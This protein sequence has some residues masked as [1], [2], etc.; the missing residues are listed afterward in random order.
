VDKLPLNKADIIDALAA[1]VDISK[2]AATKALNVVLDTICSAL[3]SG[4][5]VSLLGFGTFDVK[6]RSARTGRNPRTG[7]AIAIP[8]SNV[9]SFKAGKMLKDAVNS[10]S[11]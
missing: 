11:E 10:G 2:A 1:E 8:A 5:A 3:K 6:E 9:A 4:K 7:E